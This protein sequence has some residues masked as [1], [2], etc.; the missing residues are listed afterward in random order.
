M[1]EKSIASSLKSVHSSATVALRVDLY[2]VRS[3]EFSAIVRRGM[4]DMEQIIYPWGIYETSDIE[5]TYISP[6]LTVR[7]Q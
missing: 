5:A 4:V 2:S 1:T 6:Y 7:V 3:V